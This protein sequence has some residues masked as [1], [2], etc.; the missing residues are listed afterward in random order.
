MKDNFIEVKLH[1]YM[2]KAATKITIAA[3]PAVAARETLFKTA[4]EA[5]PGASDGGPEMERR[6]GR[7]SNRWFR[8]RI[9]S[10]RRRRR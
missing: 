10:D 1:L 6:D 7:G 2:T 5:G 8:R 9:S 4:L 3:D